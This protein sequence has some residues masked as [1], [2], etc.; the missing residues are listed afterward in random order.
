MDPL[1]ALVLVA[2]V[3][4]SFWFVIGFAAA[5]TLTELALRA[6]T[7]EERRYLLGLSGK[8]DGWFQISGGT[9]VGPTGLIAVFVLGHGWT[10][11]WVILAIVLF[12]A[13][14]FGGAV[15]WRTRSM[16]VRAALEAGDDAGVLAILRAPA[17]R[18]Q[19]WLER[20]AVA[21]IVALMILRPA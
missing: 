4:S 6:G 8:F 12:A 15:L 10:E 5:G 21:V 9:L 11:L 7:A 1:Q 20:V 19:S 2:H 18:A 14:S 16:R 3:G 13:V 17:A